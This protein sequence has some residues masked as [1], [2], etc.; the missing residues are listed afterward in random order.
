[1]VP[2]AIDGPEVRRYCL[3]EAGLVATGLEKLQ[4]VPLSQ[5]RVS[6]RVP[7]LN[8]LPPTLTTVL[9][10]VSP[11]VMPLWL[12]VTFHWV[13]KLPVMVVPASVALMVPLAILVRRYCLL[14][15]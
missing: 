7:T 11:P 9:A 3:E 8:R 12:K 6:D 14:A 13:T 1:M 2:E 15:E 4:A 5:K 10:L